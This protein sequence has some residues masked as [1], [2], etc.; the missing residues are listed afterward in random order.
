MN[1]RWFRGS[2]PARIAICVSLG[3]Y[4]AAGVCLAGEKPEI[5]DEKDRM[6]Y[7]IGY[8]IGKDFKRQGVPL[9]P[10]M[11]LQGARD[12]GSGAD[13]LMSAGEIQ[14]TLTEFKKKS[15]ATERRQRGRDLAE[16]SNFLA[17]NG[18]KEGVVTLLSGLQYAVL[19]KGSGRTPAATDNVTVHFQG[20]LLDG[21][22]FD[23][24]YRKGKPVSVRVDS[25]IPGW[26]E[27]LQLMREGDKWRIFLPPNLAYGDRKPLGGKTV[28]FEVELLSVASMTQDSAG[29]GKK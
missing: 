28:I 16:G 26:K 3:A 20:A 22:E 8:Q 2:R 19:R 21:T 29:G 18:K 23:S 10:E 13:P 6:N 25:A 11:L 24:S 7:S 15:I 17:E 5:K 14:A 1:G 27:A 12:A 9:H 4:L